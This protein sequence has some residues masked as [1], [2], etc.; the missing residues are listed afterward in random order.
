MA[1]LGLEP[2]VVRLVEYDHAWPGL[3]EAERAR[4][5]RIVATPSV[6]LHH[7]GSTAVPGLAAKPVLDLLA[8][9]PDRVD[10]AA[11]IAAFTAAGY[12]HRGE[13]GIAGRDF[14]RRGDPRSYHLHLAAA[15]SA[16]AREHLSFRDALRGDPEL[17]AAY[18]ALKRRLAAAY[19]RD[20][21]AYIAAKGPFIAEALRQAAATR[22]SSR[23]A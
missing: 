9:C 7:V 20:R 22:S 17:C 19:P 15:E 11:L 8:T 16:F 12:E 6:E 10:R 13:Q 1:S 5:L 3:F 23:P 2:K 18:Q 4:V 21:A 14:F